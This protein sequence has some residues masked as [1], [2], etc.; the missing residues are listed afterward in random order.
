MEGS[1]SRHPDTDPSDVPSDRE[2]ALSYLEGLNEETMN[3]A[4]GDQ[5]TPEERRRIVQA[6]LILGRKLDE[7]L[8]QRGEDLHPDEAQ[9]FLMSLI[10]DTITEFARQEGLDSE[11]ATGFLSDVGTRDL[12]LEL[13]E[14]LE[15]SRESGLP[16][17]DQ[18]R[19]IV[20]D[21]RERA[22]WSD[23]WSSG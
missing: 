22:I 12:I 8:A 9:R 11:A 23:H 6:A 3:A 7:R 16:L 21:R 14:V 15:A 1:G 2:R 5:R 19:Q 13:N 10:N 20:G 4:W 18:L 17:D